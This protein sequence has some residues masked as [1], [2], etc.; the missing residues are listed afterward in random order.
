VEAKMAITQA[1]SQSARIPP[2]FDHA[3]LLRNHVEICMERGYH[4][5]FLNCEV[6]DRAGG[7]PGPGSGDCYY[8][9]STVSTSAEE[10]KRARLTAADCAPVIGRAA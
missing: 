4:G 1:A 2:Q 8:C 5:P 10:E 7:V 6:Y 3:T 9:H